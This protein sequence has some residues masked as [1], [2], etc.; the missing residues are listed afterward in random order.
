M[1]QVTLLEA[2][3]HLPELL[4]AAAAGEGVVIVQDNGWAFR[5]VATPPDPVK[6]PA[7]IPRAGSCAGLIQM[8]DD[9]D[10]P[11]DELHEYME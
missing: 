10:A 5:V 2:R 7:R 6:P 9:F 1:T 3:E 4:A 8:A 11:L